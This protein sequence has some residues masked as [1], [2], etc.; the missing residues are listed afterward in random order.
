[1]QFVFSRFVIIMAI[2]RSI[3]LE[4]TWSAD[5]LKVLEQFFELKVVLIPNMP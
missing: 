2:T 5:D 4:N 1:M 3:Y